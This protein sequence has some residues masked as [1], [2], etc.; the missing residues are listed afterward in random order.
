MNL[1]ANYISFLAPSFCDLLDGDFYQY[2]Q[3]LISNHL[4]ESHQ[5]SETIHQNLTYG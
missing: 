3:I 2:S 4:L 1:S 5:K